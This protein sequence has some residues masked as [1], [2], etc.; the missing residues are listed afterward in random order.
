MSDWLKKIANS[1][2]NAGNTGLKIQNLK[3][4]SKRRGGERSQ[5]TKE[6]AEN[7]ATE[8]EDIGEKEA[9]KEEKTPRDPLHESE[10][11]VFNHK[12]GQFDHQS[13]QLKQLQIIL[14][15]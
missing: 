3:D 4:G 15:I 14:R 8:T 6:D 7:E 12:N 10:G 9:H 2:L 1:F 11:Q 5:K 13:G